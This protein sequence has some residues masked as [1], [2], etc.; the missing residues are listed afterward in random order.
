MEVAM[1]FIPIGLVAIAVILYFIGKSQSKKA[2]DIASIQTSSSGDLQQLAADISKEIG[3]GA[4]RQQAEVKGIAECA[5]PLKSEQAG[6]DCVWYRTTITR[7]YEESYT[8]RD[9]N[10]KST[11]R[12]RRGSEQVSNNERHTVFE[13]RDESGTIAIDPAE[14]K[15][16][17]EKLLSRFEQG[18]GGAA[19]SFGGITLNFGMIGGRRTLGYKIEEW[20]IP[21]G[22]RLYIL[23]EASDSRGKVHIAKPEAKGGRYL[24]SVKS[25]EQLLKSAKTGSRVLMIGS[26]LLLLAGIVSTLIIL[27]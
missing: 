14:A 19:L 25:E 12:T 10:G 16:D 4:F 20:G 15:L 24:I 1:I 11:T 7:E 23:G 9:S 3:G 17:G 18:Q 27:L 6:I 2:F 21:V 13:L 22:K 8:E 5:T 26:A